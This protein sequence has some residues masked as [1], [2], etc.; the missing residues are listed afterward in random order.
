[1]R[2]FM[3][4]PA[5]VLIGVTVL[6]FAPA[7]EAQPGS[8]SFDP[9]ST[10]YA[11]GGKFFI[12][13]ACEP[14]APSFL[15]SHAFAGQPGGTEFAGVPAISFTTSPSGTFGIGLTIDPSVPGGSY[16]VELRCAGGL[17]ASAT[18]TVLPFSSLPKTGAPD[19]ELA[20]AGAAV[21]AA[22]AALMLARRRR[23]PSTAA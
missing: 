3:F 5:L 13:V 22:G 14:N 16:N 20:L 21:I 9:S 11:G 12:N 8:I 2:R 18:L 23:A 15:I 6:L 10:V 17:A 19:T 1:M 4:V 7:A